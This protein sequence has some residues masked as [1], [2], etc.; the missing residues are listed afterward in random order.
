MGI[1]S[2]MSTH[3]L[4]NVI[5][6]KLTKNAENTSV[7]LD[8][9]VNYKYNQLSMFLTYFPHETVNNCIFN[10]YLRI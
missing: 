4:E 7:T 10:R 9:R 2:N 3:V 1:L 8:I 5:N 6:L